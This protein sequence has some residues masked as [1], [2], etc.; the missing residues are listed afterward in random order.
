MLSYV[1][2]GANDLPRSD[3][4]YSVILMPLGYEKKESA[5]ALVFSLPD[6]PDRDNGPGTVYVTRPYDGREATVGNGSMIAFQAQTHALVCTIHAA[7]LEAGG[8][9]E[10]VSPVKR[11]RPGTWRRCSDASRRR[12]SRRGRNWPP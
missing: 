12:S 10:G 9:D 2:V 4:F 5:D 7:G 1:M 11:W 3:R 8:S 6:I